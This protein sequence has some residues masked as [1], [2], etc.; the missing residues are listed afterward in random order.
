MALTTTQKQKVVFYLCWSGKSIIEGSTDYNSQVA[1]A[2]DNLNSDI[3]AQ[4]T[5]LLAQLAAIDTKMANSGNKF[6]VK[7]IGDIEF[8][9]N[10]GLDQLKGERARLGRLLSSLLGIPYR[11]R[12]SSGMVGVCN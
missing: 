7:A 1:S 5:D 6:G 4:V 9:D 3:E 2:L 12:G 8:F 10:S 11:C